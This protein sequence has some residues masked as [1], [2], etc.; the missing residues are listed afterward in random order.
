VLGCFGR[1]RVRQTTRQAAG[2]SKVAGTE[3]EAADVDLHNKSLCHLVIRLIGGGLVVELEDD[4]GSPQSKHKS[5]RRQDFLTP[6][7]SASPY[8]GSLTSK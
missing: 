5:L 2:Y 7:S 1:F 3:G 4:R 8:G 6:A